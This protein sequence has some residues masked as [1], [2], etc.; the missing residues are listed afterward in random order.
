MAAP[1]DGVGLE[2]AVHAEA[3]AGG[4]EQS[5]KDDGDGI[6]RQA[7]VAPL[8][9]ADADRAEAQAEAQVLGVPETRLHAPPFGV[10]VDDLARGRGGVAGDQ[11]LWCMD[12]AV[13]GMRRIG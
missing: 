9:V 8:R 7:P 3:L 11:V 2:V 13:A 5:E 10:A 1:L 4:A 12:A 6:E